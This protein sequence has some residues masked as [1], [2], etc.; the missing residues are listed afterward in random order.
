MIVPAADAALAVAFSPAPD[1][2]WGDTN[3]TFFA[4][5]LTVCLIKK[6]END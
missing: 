4:W 2:T 6:L 3:Q 1:E 5:G